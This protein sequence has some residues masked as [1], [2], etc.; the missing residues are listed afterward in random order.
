LRSERSVSFC[1]FQNEREGKLSVG[2]QS[3]RVLVYTLCWVTYSLIFGERSVS[4][5]C[6]QNEFAGKLSVRK[7]IPPEAHLKAL[8]FL[9]VKDINFFR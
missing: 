5:C 1:G 9:A 6:F 4:F 3:L 2:K 8:N 7:A